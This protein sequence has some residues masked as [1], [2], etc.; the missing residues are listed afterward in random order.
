MSMAAGEFVSV[1]SQADTEAADIQREKHELES[2]PA[3]EKEELAQ[4]YVAR[5]LDPDLARK[6]A[7]QLMAKDALE[8]HA[9][10][11]LGITHTGAA[12]PLQA[13]FAS[14]STFSAGASLP[15]AVAFMVPTESHGL[16]VFIASLFFLIV[17]GSLAAKIGGANPIKGAL[18]VGFWGAF[19]MAATALVGKLFEIKGF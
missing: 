2:N 8:S 19:A 6:V 7:E 4:I 18:R 3:H 14:A 16:Y 11:E 15:L 17:L 10:E 5:G 9:R 1:S 12:R 13:A